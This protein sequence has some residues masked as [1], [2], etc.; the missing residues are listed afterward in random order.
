MI[1]TFYILIKWRV[2]HLFVVFFLQYDSIR[3]TH[4]PIY[5]SILSC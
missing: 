2:A 5:G 3:S 4:R 1:Y